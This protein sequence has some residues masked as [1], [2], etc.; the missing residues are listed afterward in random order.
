MANF[1]DNLDALDTTV[2]DHL[3]DDATYIPASGTAPL[4]CR[5]IF[6]DPAQTD[7]LQNASIVRA[8]PTISVEVAVIASLVKNDLFDLGEQR[9]RVAAAPTRPGDG[10]WWFAEVDR[11]AG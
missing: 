11:V 3:C 7:V 6:D 1:S 10:R 9:W 5:V 8:K 2:R 4:P